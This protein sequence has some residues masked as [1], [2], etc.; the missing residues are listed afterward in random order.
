M[1]RMAKCTILFSIVL[2]LGALAIFIIFLR[3]TKKEF[4]YPTEADFEKIQFDM[5]YEEVETILGPPHKVLTSNS[6]R[7]E[8]Y[9][10]DRPGDKV[11]LYEG[12]VDEEGKFHHGHFQFNREGKVYGRGHGWGTQ[13]PKSMLERMLEWIQGL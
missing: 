5:T 9:R 3:G 8:F 2:L 6:S 13:K 7:N 4:Y 1:S 10:P 12:T 11:F